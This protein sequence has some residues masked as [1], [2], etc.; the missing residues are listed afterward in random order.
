MLHTRVRLGGPGPSNGPSRASGLV[1]A[2]S[3]V[4]LYAYSEETLKFVGRRS[5]VPLYTTGSM[6][7]L[8]QF[9]SMLVRAPLQIAEG[10]EAGSEAASNSR[11][12]MSGPYRA[13]TYHHVSAVSFS[14]IEKCASGGRLKGHGFIAPVAPVDPRLPAMS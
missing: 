14:R 1:G 13:E 3:A 10:T 9:H 12:Y 8:N 6:G 4:L 5:R 7:E 2:I 11:F